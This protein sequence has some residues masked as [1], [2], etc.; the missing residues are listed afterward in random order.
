[1]PAPGEA[2]RLFADVVVASLEVEGR[3][4]RPLRPVHLLRTYRLYMRELPR[5]DSTKTAAAAK[6]VAVHFRQLHRE[7]GVARKACNNLYE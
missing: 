1:M 3:V 4:T 2:S 6:T 5:P 7:H